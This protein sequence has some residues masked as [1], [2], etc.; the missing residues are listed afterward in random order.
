MGR[1]NFNLSELQ[2]FVAVSDQLNFRAA[3]EA[4]HISA[5]ALSRRISQLESMLGARLLDRSTRTV[6][7]T[8]LGRVFLSHARAVLNELENGILRISDLAANRSGQV[9]IGCVASATYHFLPSVLSTFNKQYPKIRVRVIDERANHVLNCVIQGEADFGLNFVGTQEPEVI[10]LPILREEY[11]L[12]VPKSHR[13][14]KRKSVKW[15]ELVDE[16]FMST[17]KA[18]GNR[19]L[20]DYALGNLAKRPAAFFEAEH[21][22]TLISMVE[23]GLGVAAVPQMAISEHSHPNIIGVPLEKPV[24]RR[25]LG[26]ISSRRR[27]LSPPAKVLY[28]LLCLAAKIPLNKSPR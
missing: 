6:S 18:T 26:L 24:I 25:R 21:V 15:E 19:L 8:N 11:V 22:A 17:S 13:F 1:I 16:R 28:D 9:T 10:F 12:A 5:P 23:A 2:A 7:L 20:M 27:P 3:A 4:L 14:A